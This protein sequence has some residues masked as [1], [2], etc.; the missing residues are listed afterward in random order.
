L[1]KRKA[2][3]S[4]AVLHSGSS[5]P[6]LQISP[7][8]T[9]EISGTLVIDDSDPSEVI[10]TFTPDSDLPV[11]LIKCTVDGCLA[12]DW[13]IEVVDDFVWTFDTNWDVLQTTWGAVKAEF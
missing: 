11:D 7:Q 6:V 3:L 2:A 4:G 5:L 8:S 1:D 9:G 13:G 10:C 12:N